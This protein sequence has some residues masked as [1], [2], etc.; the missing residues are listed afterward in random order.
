MVENKP[1]NKRHKDTSLEATR[2]EKPVAT[3]V[4]KLA[5][6]IFS[7]SASEALHR[8]LTAENPGRMIQSMSRVDF[9]WLVK[10]IGE[11]DASVVLSMASAEQWEY[12][13]DMEVWNR[14]RLDLTKTSEWLARLEDADATRLVQWLCGEQESLAFF[15][16]FKKLQVE[17]KGKDEV[18]ELGGD[19]VSFDGIYFFRVLDKE[20]EEVIKKILRR[21][22]LVDF[23]RYR[24]LLSS[25][26]G[27]LSDELEEG[28]YRLRNVR[29]AEYGFL[30]YDEAISL[31]SHLRPEAL[32]A[33]GILPQVEQPIREGEEETPA[34]VIPLIH[35]PGNNLFMASAKRVAD[36]FLMDR[37]RLEFA[38][39]CNQILAADGEEVRDIDTL[40][41][42]CRKAAGYI[43]LGLDRATEGHLPAAEELVRKNALTSIFRVGF[44]LALELKWEAERWVK[45]AWFK[46]QGFNISFWGEKWGSTLEGLLEKRPRLFQGSQKDEPFK[47]FEKTAELEE[48]RITIKRLIALDRLLEVLAFQ[49]TVNSEWVRDPVFTFHPMVFNLW[50]RIQMGLKLGFGSLSLDQAKAFFQHL[51]ANEV[52]APYRMPGFADRFVADLTAYASAPQFEGV[53]D[54]EK[55]LSLL[56]EN[57]VEEYAWVSVSELDE[58]FITFLRVR[59]DGS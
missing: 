57:F 51:R 49:Y 25:L 32:T 39:L 42:V 14:D 22:A 33:Q 44:G 10:K 50:A 9:Y 1:V 4:S 21:L 56:W 31:Y 48:C 36:P 40:L 7:L 3:A 34:P 35:A 15:Y 24:A 46:R 16:F 18:Y 11:D 41:R 17:I 38:G 27:A 6:E 8:V 12:L 59:S 58:R 53:D 19:F 45:K 2:E 29:L 13:L 26:A 37:I 20:Y 30:P 23:E 55:T 54:L 43:H 28:M 47:D 52:S 5:E